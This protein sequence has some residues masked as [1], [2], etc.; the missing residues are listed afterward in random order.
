[1]QDPKFSLPNVCFKF[2]LQTRCNDNHSQC[3]THKL[4]AIMDN[5]KLRL[6]VPVCLHSEFN[7]K[8]QKKLVV[9]ILSFHVMRPAKKK[10]PTKSNQLEWF[11]DYFIYFTSNFP[12][13]CNCC[14]SLFFSPLQSSSSSSPFPVVLLIWTSIMLK[15]IARI[16]DLS[17]GAV[18]TLFPVACSRKSPSSV[19]RN[20]KSALI[21][22]EELL[23]LLYDQRPEEGGFTCSRDHTWLQSVEQKN[24]T[25]HCG[26][27]VSKRRAKETRTRSHKQK[28]VVEQI[29]TR[30]HMFFFVFNFSCCCFFDGVSVSFLASSRR[31]Y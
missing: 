16:Y 26:L 6:V 19:V 25:Q 3:Q 28:K 2:K 30:C 17:R 24:I 9:V 21:T 14:Y 11:Y 29:I 20:T 5:N 13:R 18:W 4:P 31:W 1:M 8:Q 22:Y 27:H 23:L 12:L 15:F 7:P 10:S